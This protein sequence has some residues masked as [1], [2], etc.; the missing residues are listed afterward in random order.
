MKNEICEIIAVRHG[1][2]QANSTGILQG[3]LDIAL[4]DMGLAQATAAAERL[5]EIHF[6]AAYSSD[7]SRAAE[8]A[9]AVL[10]YHQEI[11]PV[12]TESLREW[13]LGELQGRPHS[14]LVQEYPAIMNSFKKGNADL[15]VPGGETLYAFQKRISS[16]M[17]EI[18][19][20]HA[21]QRILFV[22]HGGALQRMFAHTTGLLDEKNIRPLC[23]NAGI[24]VFRHLPG[25]WQLVTWSETGHLAHL[26]LRDTLTY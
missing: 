20:R 23:A 4:D 14:E 9:K 10:K 1:Q 19:A 11:K 12:L 16:F 5:K 25:G 7:L 18:A 8:T 6:D 24:S 15:Q 22:S 26:Q 17:D 13:N 3:H 2:T 21:G